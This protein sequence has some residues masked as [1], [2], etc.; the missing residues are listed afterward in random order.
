MD[1]I[2][3]RNSAF[4]FSSEV[5][6][7]AVSTYSQISILSTAPLLLLTMRFF[8]LLTVLVALLGQACATERFLEQGNDDS[9]DYTSYKM[10][11]ARCLRTKILEDND[12]EGNSYFYNGSYR[13]QSIS[14]ASFYLC[15]SDSDSDSKCGTCDKTTEYVTDLENYL[16]STADYVQ[17][18]CGKC[19]NQCRRRLEDGEEEEDGEDEEEED[20]EDDQSYSVDCDTC[21]SKCA[22]LTSGN[23]GTDESQYLDCQASFVDDSGNQIYSAPTCGSDQ[24]LTMGLFYDGT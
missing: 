2:Q 4:F 22:L 16:E 6:V 13:S 14:Y 19:T 8:G 18:Y 20:Q 3:D 15:A 1:Y 5:T 17:E 21:S 11:F 12:D 24:G 7:H 10:K 9:V 23:E